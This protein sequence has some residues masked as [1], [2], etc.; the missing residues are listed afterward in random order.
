MIKKTKL[1]LGVVAA[2]AVA[3]LAFGAAAPAYADPS[4]F[5]PLNG[6]GS[7]TT[8]DVMSGVASAVT[9]I[10]S[11][12]AIGSATIQT[13][14]GGPI[15][16]RPNGSTSGVQ[17][18]SA[19]V[20]NTGTRVFPATAAGV[21]I[22]GQLDFARSSSAPSSSFVGTDLT[23]IPFARDAVT[24]AVSLASDF[25]RDIALGAASQ[26]TISPAPFTLYSL[27]ARS[28]CDRRSRQVTQVAKGI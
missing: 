14:S 5:K 19:S 8:Q 9:A 21:S 6:A 7:D 17:A 26:D 27:G 16:T 20:N 3:V 10:G 11:Y 1:R 23:F 28:A 15:F 22:T 24:F 13:T 25:P 12:D 18:L 4:G 2:T